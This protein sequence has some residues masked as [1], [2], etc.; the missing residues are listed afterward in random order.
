M[1]NL[2][3]KYQK[4]IVPALREEFGYENAYAAPKVEKVVVNTGVGRHSKE[5]DYLEKVEEMLKHITGQKPARRAS[6]KSIA[7]FKIREGATVGMQVTLRGP[8]MYDFLERMTA[9]VFPRLRDFRGI[10]IKG[11]DGRGNYTFG[12]PDISA[13]PEAS[14]SDSDLGQGIEI[15]VVTSAK[16]D[17][18]AEAL[19]RKLDFPFK[20]KPVSEPNK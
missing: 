9:V 10:K 19:L 1:S 18:E 15:V 14:P 4:E 7:G 8:R 11:F 20:K 17:K 5:A 16:T 2:K 6:R 3:E 13:F 12:M